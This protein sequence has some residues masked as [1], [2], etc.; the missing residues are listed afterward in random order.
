[1]A[2]IMRENLLQKLRDDLQLALCV[3]I[4][5]F[6][7]RLDSLSGASA[8]VT[9]VEY[10]NQLKEEFLSCRNVWL[11]SLTRGISTSDPYQHVSFCSSY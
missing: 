4:V 8:S 7:R 10:E 6:L 11:S 3:R 1:M 5:S 9:P 2:K